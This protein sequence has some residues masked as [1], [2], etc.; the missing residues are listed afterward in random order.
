MIPKSRIFGLALAALLAV[1]AV[2]AQAAP[3]AQFHSEA[4][5][6]TVEV[7]STSAHTFEFT[8]GLKFS[9]ELSTFKG[10]IAK[11]AENLTLIPT[12]SSCTMFVGGSKLAPTVNF[13]GCDYRLSAG[14][15]MNVECPLGKSI[16]LAAAGCTVKI[17]A[18]L[19]LKPVTYK[20]TE[21]FFHVTWGLS[22]VS[23]SHS[24]FLCGTGSGTTGTY[25]GSSKAVG[26]NSGG[27][28]VK[29][30]VE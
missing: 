24:G 14:G 20:N 22:N 23:F 9:C 28:Q 30:W 7:S 13:N 2:A 11:T 8:P 1:T 3:A 4:E 10:T 15:T 18:Q 26:K 25:T 12:Y 16:E 21:T 6:T 19:A 27:T 5:P 17:P 29:F